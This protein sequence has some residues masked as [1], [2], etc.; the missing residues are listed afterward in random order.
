MAVSIVFLDRA[1]LPARIA[2]PAPAF[3]HHW[4]E[5]PATSPEQVV[6]RLQ[7]AT[8]AIVNKVRIGEAELAA[9][10]QLRL[11]AVAATGTDNVDLESC[12]RRGVAVC[13]VQGYAVH[14]VV[15]HALALMLAL[16]RNLPAYQSALRA[17]AWQQSPHFCYFGP[18]IHD[19]AG[20]KLGLIGSGVLGR[21]M[22]RLAQALGMEVS[23]AARRHG[24]VDHAPLHTTAD[25]VER[26]PRLPF[27]ELLGSSDVI[28]LH[29]PLNDETRN[30][31]GAREFGLMKPGS[32]LI[33][34]ARG[35]LL[36][37][38]ALLQALQSGHLAGAASDVAR[39]EPPQAG[40][41]LLRALDLPNFILTPHVAW[42]SDEAMQTL[43]N[44]V[45]ANLEAFQRGESLRRVV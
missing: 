23:F 34:T 11:I 19:L 28:S 18:G 21:N 40:D 44:Q 35:A 8:M 16:A 4:Q 1:T 10:P 25:T 37:E 33:N 15:E 14:A 12:R 6:P 29:C 43:A 24:T 5:Y 32:L 17:G 13:N 31:F 38:E 26:L 22:A 27:D 30:M 3:V 20:K 42:A 45:I 7:G 9:L 36:D 2:L 41:P 39:R